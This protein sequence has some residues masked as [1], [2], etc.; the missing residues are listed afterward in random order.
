PDTSR[1]ACRTVRFAKDAQFLLGREAA[2]TRAQDEFRRRGVRRRNQRRPAAILSFGA[3]RRK[4][5]SI[6]DRG[7]N[8]GMFRPRPSR[9][10]SRWVI[11]STSLAQR[12]FE[13]AQEPVLVSK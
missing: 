6:S 5:L 12:A 11:V 3:G 1:N 4:S 10:N 7:H 2:A 9:V 13:N 8:H